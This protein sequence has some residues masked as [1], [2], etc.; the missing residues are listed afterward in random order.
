MVIFGAL[1]HKIESPAFSCYFHHSLAV[2][3]FLMSLV[4]IFFLFLSAGNSI[5]PKQQQ[6]CQISVLE[7][8][9]EFEI[10]CLE[11][12]SFRMIVV[13]YGQDV[14]AAF[15]VHPI[16]SRV[17]E[18][19]WGLCKCICFARTVSRGTVISQEPVMQNSANGFPTNS[20]GAK[21]L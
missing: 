6:P 9:G 13:W 8:M 16:I 11:T 1:L 3:I 2:V 10:Q 7:S 12:G 21:K 20:N 14:S 15:T 18:G 17:I 19:Y 4:S 5:P